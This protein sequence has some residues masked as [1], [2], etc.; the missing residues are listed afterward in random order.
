ML[1]ATFLFY[2]VLFIFLFS[3]PGRRNPN[4][5]NGLI[6]VLVL[7]LLLAA[8]MVVFTV[9]KVYFVYKLFMLLFLAVLSLLTYWQWGAQ[10][11]RWFRS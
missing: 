1:V 3:R 5:G 6:P 2:L 10:I 8:L 4:K 7:P 9:I 11:R